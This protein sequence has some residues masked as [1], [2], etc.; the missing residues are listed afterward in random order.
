MA[1]RGSRSGQIRRDTWVTRF[2]VVYASGS[3]AHHFFANLV[4]Q[5]ILGCRDA[6]RRSLFQTVQVISSSNTNT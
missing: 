5:E 2:R 1:W 6:C 4:S 3:F